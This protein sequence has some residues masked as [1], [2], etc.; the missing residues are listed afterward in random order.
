VTFSFKTSHSS[1]VSFR[2]L[3]DTVLADIDIVA[4][5]V[6]IHP[7]SLANVS[8]FSDV[9]AGQVADVAKELV[10]FFDVLGMSRLDVLS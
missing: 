3:L 7:A 10:R 4:P 5:K 6:R 2:Y 9:F 1:W 8:S